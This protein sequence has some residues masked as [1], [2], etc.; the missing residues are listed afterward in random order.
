M[1]AG[2]ER[3][4]QPPPRP[5]DTPPERSADLPPE[6]AEAFARYSGS[7]PPPPQEPPPKKH[8]SRWIWVSAILAL[9]CVGLLVWALSLNSDLDDANAK[10]QQQQETG[11]SIAT[12][13]KDAYDSLASDLGATNEDLQQTEEQLQGAQDDAQKAQ[14]DADAAKQKAENTSDELDK[15]KAEADQA[16]AEAEVAGSKAKVAAECAKAYISAA[17]GLLSGD[18]KDAVKQTLQGITDECRAAFEAA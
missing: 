13:A 14:E 2:S 9:G 18:D 11:T 6:S 16:K 10:N 15:A 17:G 7:E 12:A 3:P 5:A 1:G 8:R 4:D